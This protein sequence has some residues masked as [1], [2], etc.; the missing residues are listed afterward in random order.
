MAN[1]APVYSQHQLANRLGITRSNGAVF[2]YVD[3]LE[4]DQSAGSSKNVFSRVVAKYSIPPISSKQKQLTFNLIE[5]L[6]QA[7]KCI[8]AGS[9]IHN[10]VVLRDSSQKLSSDVELTLGYTSEDI[11]TTANSAKLAARID[12]LSGAVLSRHPAVSY[13]QLLSSTEAAKWA[14]VYADEL[15]QNGEEAPAALEYSGNGFY[16]EAKNLF[17]CVTVKGTV[18]IEDIL[19]VISYSPPLDTEFL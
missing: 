5:E 8:P 17:P 10:V 6:T 7:P 12:V 3:S 19:V 9:F 1:K 4:V 18:S 11:T 15:V 13:P 14:E 2:S 16:C